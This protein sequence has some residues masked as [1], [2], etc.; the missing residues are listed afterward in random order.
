[1][2]ERGS[3]LPERGLIGAGT[4]ARTA[5]LDHGVGRGVSIGL[6]GSMV[7]LGARVGIGFRRNGIGSARVGTDRLGTF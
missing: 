2:L 1:M 3:V 7:G 4:F 5:R 6:W